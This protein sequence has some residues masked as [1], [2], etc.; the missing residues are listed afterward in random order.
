DTFKHIRRASHDL[1]A[2]DVE[3]H[4]EQGT[5]DRV[6][7][8]TGR[9]VPRVTTA[10][11]EDLALAAAGQRLY[12]DLRLVPSIG[13]RAARDGEKHGVAARRTFG[14]CSRFAF[15]APRRLSGLPPS[16]GTRMIPPAPPPQ[17]IPLWP[18]LMP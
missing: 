8:M 5:A 10:L 13:R 4:G 12:D 16:S 2:F 18:Q 7:Q 17:G 1:Q 6:H 15:F 11:H 9:Q 3:G 14:P